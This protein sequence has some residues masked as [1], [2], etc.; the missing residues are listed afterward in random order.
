MEFPAKLIGFIAYGGASPVPENIALEP[1]L[2]VEV[3]NRT[4]CNFEPLAKW[5]RAGA[6]HLG[7]YGWYYGGGV[8]GYVVPR[9]YPHIIGNAWK[10]AHRDFG[11][12][13]AWLETGGAGLYQGALHYVLNELAW[14]LSADI[15][16]LL[17]DYFTTF[18]VEAA[19]PMRQFF[20]RIEAIYARKPD[21]LN[22]PADCSQRTLSPRRSRR[23]SF[24]STPRL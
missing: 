9:H 6:R 15:D 17:E 20:D 5:K 10:K 16:G 11:L 23:H 14:N 8:S 12:Q 19:R 2:Y 7:I 4:R 21:P 24:L 18:Y 22:P 3:M 1:N 13:G